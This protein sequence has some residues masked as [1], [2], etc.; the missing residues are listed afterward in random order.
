MQKIRGFI[1]FEN[2]TLSD[3]KL[4]FGNFRFDQAT[5]AYFTSLYKSGQTINC[6]GVFITGKVNL[7]YTSVNVVGLL[8]KLMNLEGEIKNYDLS[9]ENESPI[10]AIKTG[11][12]YGEYI[13][14]RIAPPYT[15]DNVKSIAGKIAKLIS[16]H[17]VWIRE[18]GPGDKEPALCI[19]LVSDEDF[20][21][22]KDKVEKMALELNLKIDSYTII[23]LYKAV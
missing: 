7:K 17:D 1:Y 15:Q 20:N 11:R 16:A 9:I 22:N 3:V 14:I 4:A 10:G 18:V 5:F 19:D 2:K 6:P 8:R 12:V 23:N 21:K 13:G